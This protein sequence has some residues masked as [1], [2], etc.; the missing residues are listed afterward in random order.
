MKHLII[1][2]IPTPWR[3]PVFER[4]CRA[5]GPGSEVVYFKGNETRRKWS[6]ELGAHP[7]TVLRAITVRTGDTERFLNP[8]ILPF[9]V[10]R[11]PESAIVFAS[12]KDPSGWLALTACRA[13]GIRVALLD[14]SWLGRDRAV[15]R[16]QRWARGLVYNRL[17]DAFVGTSEQT[18]AMFRHYNARIRAEQCFLSH[19]V[20]DNEYFERRL[21][22]AHVERTFDVMFSGRI[23]SV[24]NP[25]FFAEV[26]GAIKAR[27][28]RCRVLVIGD[29]DHRL[30]ARMR[31]TFARHGVTFEFSGFIS[32]AELPEYYASAR[33][34]MLPT[35]GDCWGV[36]INEA[37]IA[38][39]PVITTEW[40][41]AAG[42]LV[43]HDRNGF[44]LPFDVN[45]WASAACSL[46]VDEQRWEQFSSVARLDVRAFNYDRAAEGLLAAFAYLRDGVNAAPSA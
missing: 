16:A 23:V 26:C 13:L 7:R 3:E 9:L 29:G 6:F 24:K 21:A 40:T 25:E 12:I 8:G 28:G 22:S 38:G 15:N 2:D 19:L 44:V 35:S 46:I 33:L 32:H 18:L 20:A 4:V 41:A 39:T 45:A 43:R 1:S 37:M 10:N 17:G 11:R 31:E 27:I 30:K 34:L 14:D 36:V 42:E 5:L